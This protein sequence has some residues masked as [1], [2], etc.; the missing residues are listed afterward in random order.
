MSFFASVALLVACGD[1]ALNR[2]MVIVGNNDLTTI[3]NSR[4]L[5]ENFNSVQKSIGLMTG[6]CTAFHLGNGVVATAAHCVAVDEPKNNAHIP[7]QFIDIKW[8]ATATEKPYLTS[9]CL[10]V[11]T[12]TQANNADIAILRVDPI[13]EWA[14]EPARGQSLVGSQLSLMGYAQGTNLQWSKGCGIY[15]PNET[16]LAKGQF[17][18]Q[19]DSEPGHSGS[20]VFNDSLK[21]I[22]VHDGGDKDWN[23]GTFLSFA[24]VE[25]MKQRASSSPTDVAVREGLTMTFG[26]FDNSENK[27]LATIPSQTAKSVSLS[28]SLDIEKDYDILR[29]VDGSGKIRELSGTTRVE[30]EHLRT[31]ISLA[32]VSD[33]AGPSKSIGI[34]VTAVE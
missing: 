32:Y 19:C 15:S 10:E 4:E 1:D 14:L 6:K 17:I 3:N 25:N 26:P 33:Y 28:F 31:P 34:T 12:L 27:L 5:P 21:V 11:L 20:P 7:C 18:H 23:Y 30:M 29:I 13:P 24:E 22:G 9:R 16:T 8:G 2:S